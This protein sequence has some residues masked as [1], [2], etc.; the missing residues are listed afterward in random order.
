MSSEGSHEPRTDADAG[1]Q[2][3]ARSRY[4]SLA[5]GWWHLWSWALPAL[6]F[7]LAGQG[8]L[9]YAPHFLIVLYPLVV[10]AGLLPCLI[11]RRRGA[12]ETPAMMVPFVLVQWWAT[13]A[14]VFLTTVMLVFDVPI[15]RLLGI[16]HLG[17]RYTDGMLGIA[18]V[19]AVAAW[20]VCLVMAILHR[21]DRKSSARAWAALA[22]AT[23]I[24]APVLIVAVTGGALIATSQQRDAANTTLTEALTAPTSVQAARFEEHYEHLNRAVSEVRALIAEDGW[25]DRNT[26]PHSAVC[27]AEGGA[28]CYEFEAEFSHPTVGQALDRDELASRLGDAGWE[29]GEV[30]TADRTDVIGLFATD[31]EGILVVV[32]LDDSAA[33]VTVQSRTGPWWGGEEILIGALG[34]YPDESPDTVYRADEWPALTGVS[35]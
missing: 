29:V 33:E 20:L 6:W 22:R 28:E 1:R 32:E 26:G 15:R 12:R 2:S 13:V 4:R 27:P 3:K 11:A 8:W 19:I 9:Y 10:F 31:A 34:G 18:G 5:W 14:P 35:D 23:A 16:D 21:K 30:K 17:F 25:G 24:A 7:V